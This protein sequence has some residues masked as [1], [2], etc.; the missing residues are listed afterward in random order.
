MPTLFVTG[1]NRG[2][3]LEFVRQYKAAGWDVIA[4]VR[5]HSAEIDQLGAEVRMLD[6][7][8]HAAVAEVRSS[9]RR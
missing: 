2:L 6:L 5:E 8:H 4:T 9:V 3:G 1:A 7:G